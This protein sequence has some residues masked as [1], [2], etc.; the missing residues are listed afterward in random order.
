MAF[1]RYGTPGDT[2]WLQPQQLDSA[3]LLLTS[4]AMVFPIPQLTWLNCHGKAWWKISWQFSTPCPSLRYVQ[5]RNFCVIH[6]IEHIIAQSWMWRLLCKSFF[7]RKKKYSGRPMTEQ[8]KL[9]DLCH[10]EFNWYQS[11]YLLNR[12]QMSPEYSTFWLLMMPCMKGI[13]CRKGFR[14]KTSIWPCSLP[15]GSRMWCC[16]NWSSTSCGKPRLQRTSR[17]ILHLQMEG[18]VAFPLITYYSW[19]QIA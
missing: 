1:L 15:P 14:S 16:D 5:K 19:H 13:S 10:M 7:W 12:L 2:R 4:L 9:V 8:D 11:I 18:K 17:G 6:G 3:L